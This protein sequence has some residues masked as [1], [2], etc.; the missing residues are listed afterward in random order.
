LLTDDALLQYAKITELPEAEPLN[1]RSLRQWIEAHWRTDLN[2]SG[3]GSDSWGK[4]GHSSTAKKSLWRQFG[5]LLLSIFHEVK[6]D[7][8]QPDLDLVVPG[9]G[10]D[11]DSL[12]RWVAGQW[13]PF[14]NNFSET[15]FC[16]VLCKPF[17]HKEVQEEKLPEPGGILDTRSNSNAST[18]SSFKRWLPFQRKP[19]PVENRKEDNLASLATYSMKGMIRFTNGVAT[20]VA[21]L[22][23]IV[24]IVVL[25]RLHTNAKILGFIA[26]FT[27]IFAI[28]IMILTDASTSRTE[29]FTATAA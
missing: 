2:I 13:I 8:G 25:S 4:L 15:P 10:R 6:L 29:I 3:P 23:P 9:K 7:K 1:V 24:G 21:C 19:P 11:I 17:G 20:I 22:F 12:T 18:L 16:R 27:A 28:G 5:G 14:W 26:L